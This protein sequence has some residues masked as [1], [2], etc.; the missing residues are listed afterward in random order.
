[1]GRTHYNIEY[2]IIILLAEIV[3]SYTNL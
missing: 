1:L 3:I 2:K